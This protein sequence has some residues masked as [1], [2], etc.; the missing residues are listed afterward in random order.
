MAKLM[1]KY[2]RFRANDLKSSVTNDPFEIMES[3]YKEKYTSYRTRWSAAYET[4]DFPKEFP[5]HI[6]IDLQ[7][8][9]NQNCNICHQ[10]YRNRT[11]AIMPVDLLESIIDEGAI[12]GL[13]ALNFGASAEPLLQKHLL[14]HGINYASDRG[15]MDIF[16]H[17]NGILLDESFSS[18]L[19]DSGLKHLCI[20]LDAV[21]ESTYRNTRNSSHFNHIVKNVNRF[22]QMRHKQK[23]SLPTIRLSFCVSPLNYT[24]A[25]NF[26]H[27]WNGKVDLVELQ[28]YRHVDSSIDVQKA[29]QK[30]VFRCANPFRRIMIWPEGDVTLCCGY[31][32]DDVFLGN[33]R[34]EEGITISKMWRGSKLNRIRSAFGNNTGLPGTCKLC[35]NSGYEPCE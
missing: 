31:R 34:E 4:G 22:C 29:F 25:E 32:Y 23:K 5:L 18:R 26:V 21:S 14:L 19:L 16:V 11:N 10:R 20:S 24:E 7:D 35:Y 27:E 13:C 1:S 8:A 15:I 9:C 12:C 6:D 30:K 33:L 2:E 3:I 28:G 17:T